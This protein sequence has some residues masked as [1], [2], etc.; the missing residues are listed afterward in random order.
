[1]QNFD[2]KRYTPSPKKLLRASLIEVSAE[3]RLILKKI[4]MGRKFRDYGGVYLIGGP[5]NTGLNFTV[6]QLNIG[7]QYAQSQ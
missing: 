1:M 3:Y 7:A 5:L 6:P 2:F 4:N